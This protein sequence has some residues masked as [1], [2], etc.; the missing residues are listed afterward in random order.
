MERDLAAAAQ[1]DAAGGVEERRELGE[2]AAAAR[3]RDRGELVAQVV[4]ERHA[5]EPEQPP[6]VLD[7]ER[8][9]AADPAGARRRGGTGRTSAKRLR[10]Q[11]V[12][13]RPRRARVAGERGELAVG[14]DLAP[15][16]VPQHR[17][18]I[19]LERRAPS[20][21]SSHVGEVVGLAGEEAV[22]PLQQIRR[23]S[24]HCLVTVSPIACL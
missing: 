22:E 24:R 3:R 11:N 10:A 12:P 1:V 9:V 4:R 5:L 21:S 7:A 13:G 17:G 15:R 2:P 20:R 14:D 18:G 19:A 16:H 23:R 6:L 8:A